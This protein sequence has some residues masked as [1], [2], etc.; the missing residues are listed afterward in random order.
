MEKRS[1]GVNR[2]GNFCLLKVSGRWEG[3][4][5]A[6]II[7]V[8]MLGIVGVLIAVQFKSQKPEYGIYIGFAIGILIFCY[9]LRQFQAALTQLGAIQK[10][11]GGGESY[12]TILLKV[13]GITYIC[14]FSAG[15]CKDAGYGSIAEQIEVIGKLSVMF[16]GLPILFA[17]IEQIQAFMG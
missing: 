5:M 1:S 17:V 3:S 11:L 12:L 16:A 15:I 4:S 6:E 10:Y 8:G 7:K 9:A 14:E 2:P 13:I